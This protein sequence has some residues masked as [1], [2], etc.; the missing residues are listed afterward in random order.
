MYAAISILSDRAR[1][2]SDIMT[3][4]YQCD[5]SI[6]TK[7]DSITNVRNQRQVCKVMYFTTQVQSL[8]EAATSPVVGIRI[9]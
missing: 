7:L 2:S 1:I 9:G 8:A 5:F 6:F 3:S 4:L